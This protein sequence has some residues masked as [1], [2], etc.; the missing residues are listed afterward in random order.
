VLRVPVGTVIYD[1]TT[2]ELIADLATDGARRGGRQGG[3]GGPRQHPLQ[4]PV[5][6]GAAHRRAGTP[7]EERTLRLELKL[8]ADVG[9]LGFPNVGKSTFIS[10]G[11]ARPAQDRRL[12]VHHAGAQPRR[13]AGCPTSAPWSSPTSP[14]LIEGAAEGA[15][16]RPPVPAPRRALSR[17]AAHPRRHL[18]PPWPTTA[19]A[20]QADFDIINAELARYAP[21]PRRQAAAGRAQQARRRHH[22]RH[23]ST[24]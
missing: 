15:G 14:G 7:G 11:V 6:P 4:D 12:P 19:I 24:S 13:G 8:L 21:G 18:T 10:R 16:P 2:G 9:L 3:K 23:R 17:A 1:E 20:A 5:E 22:P